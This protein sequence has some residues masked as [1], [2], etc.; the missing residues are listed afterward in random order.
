VGDSVNVPSNRMI[1]AG[2]LLIE[3]RGA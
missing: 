1:V 2:P 3:V